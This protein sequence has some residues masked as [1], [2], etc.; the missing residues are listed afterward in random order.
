VKLGSIVS[1]SLVSGAFAASCGASPNAPL[2][3]A[4]GALPCADQVTALHCDT[5]AEGALAADADDLAWMLAGAKVPP[6]DEPPVTLTAWCDG[7]LEAG[8]LRMHVQLFQGIDGGYVKVPGRDR[9]W[10]ASPPEDPA[11]KAARTCVEADLPA[12]SSLRVVRCSS[13]TGD[14][15]DVISARDLIDR[16]RRIDRA[17][18]GSPAPRGSCELDGP[19]G[20]PPRVD[21]FD[22]DEGWFRLPAG[23]RLCFTTKGA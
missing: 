22:R 4:D 14:K 8:G 9:V 19:P 21:F 7:T 16:A 6:L 1:L 10:F 20:S 11:A 5:V 12:P 2:H 18:F 13:A 3:C 23:K 17:A 15:I